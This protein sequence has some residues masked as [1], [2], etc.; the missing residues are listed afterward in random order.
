MTSHFIHRC[1]LMWR[2]QPNRWRISNSTQRQSIV[3]LR[4]KHL[5]VHKEAAHKLEATVLDRDSWKMEMEVV[6]AVPRNRKILIKSGE[7]QV[8]GCGASIL[9]RNE[10]KYMC[11]LLQGKPILEESMGPPH[12]D[13]DVE[14][15]NV[16]DKDKLLNEEVRTIFASTT[17]PSL[18]L[19]VR[20]KK[21]RPKATLN[22]G[23]H[24]RLQFTGCHV[25]RSLREWRSLTLIMSLGSPPAISTDGSSSACSV[26]PIP[27]LR[28]INRPGR[29][30]FPDVYIP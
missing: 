7:H 9:V 27:F 16:N 23:K 15:R 5:G 14:E 20:Q 13:C 18:S 25:R 29:C 3:K 6:V 11:S 19:G 26:A 1:V 21:D 10:R 24:Y 12:K 22:L 30:T 28:H 4:N 2:T 17:E 8:V